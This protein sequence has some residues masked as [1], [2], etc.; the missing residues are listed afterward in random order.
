VPACGPCTNTADC[1]P[2][3][4]CVVAPG[5]THGMCGPCG[6]G[7]GG[8]AGAPPDGGGPGGP[9]DG[10]GGEGGGGSGSCSQYGQICQAAANCCNGLPCTNGRCI[11]AAL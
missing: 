6:G 2:G 9:N 10:G 8:D 7:G 1:C 3:S 5:S 4:S 11:Q